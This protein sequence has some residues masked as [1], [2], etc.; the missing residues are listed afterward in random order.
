MS[1]L[2]SGL[3]S[4]LAVFGFASPI[5]AAGVNSISAGQ[6]SS[7]PI[8][9][10]GHSNSPVASAT[11]RSGETNH[12]AIDAWGARL[13]ELARKGFT[14]QNPAAF[15]EWLDVV[16]EPQYLTALA[17]VPLDPDRTLRVL[18]Q[19]VNPRSA[20]SWSEYTD[21]GLTMRR[22]LTGTEGRYYPAILSQPR[23]A[24]FLDPWATL[25]SNSDVCG[26]LRRFITQ[27][28]SARLGDQ[29]GDIGHRESLA[30]PGGPAD[31]SAPRAAE[32]WLRLPET[33]PDLP[34]LRIPQ[35][36]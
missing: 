36:Y 12:Y 1:S 35:R 20:R 21:L 17:T 7:T 22:V 8:A 24:S 33:S 31:V 3:A 9:G 26:S 13:R 30:R 29:A 15:I 14:F 34:V 25:V 18:G 32:V 19:G 2:L 6:G 5:W 10:S 11:I 4:L 16:S 27:A 23:D 28:A